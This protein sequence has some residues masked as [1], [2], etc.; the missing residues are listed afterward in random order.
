MTAHA[1]HLRRPGP[2][3][4]F[5]AA[6]YCGRPADRATADPA[7]VSCGACLDRY[8]RRHPEAARPLAVA[9]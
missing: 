9:P 8:R 5:P 6:T 7:Q 3:D 4:G 1:V 2:A